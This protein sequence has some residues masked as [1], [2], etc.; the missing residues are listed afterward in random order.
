MGNSTM[1][2]LILSIAIT[3]FLCAIPLQ[4]AAQSAAGPSFNCARATTVVERTICRSPTFAAKDRAI[5]SL[6]TRVRD[7]T[8]PAR[9]A[10][11]ARNQAEFNR[12]RS[13]CY[14]PD[15]A[16]DDCLDAFMGGRITE[17]NGWLRSGYR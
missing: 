1:K 15:Q 11:F 9:R 16:Q 17:L 8:P 6:Y 2:L 14:T 5:A 13:Y 12:N 3:T 4:V 7:V 10:A